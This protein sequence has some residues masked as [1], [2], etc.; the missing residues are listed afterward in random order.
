MDTKEK[1]DVRRNKIR[2]SIY[3]RQP[4]I[5]L[6]ES[7]KYMTLSARLSQVYE[8]YEMV[9]MNAPALPSDLEEKL[10]VFLSRNKVTPVLIRHLDNEV[11]MAQYYDTEDMQELSA[12]I[13]A[14]N[15]AERI[16]LIESMGF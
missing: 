11:L 3:L 14:M 9:C 12:H 13:N 4:L 6:N 5:N 1:D 16:A 8:R 2:P 10:S 15:I 7:L